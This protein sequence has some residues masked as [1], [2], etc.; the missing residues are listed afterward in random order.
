M[1]PAEYQELLSDF[2]REC[3]NRRIR[4]PIIDEAEGAHVKVSIF[5][6]EKH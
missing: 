6:N 3:E 5:Q 4:I 2:S 1:S